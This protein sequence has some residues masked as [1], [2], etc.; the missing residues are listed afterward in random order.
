MIKIID[1]LLPHQQWQELHDYFL[2]H[3]CPW[4]YR[5]CM[6]CKDEKNTHFQF[7]QAMFLGSGVG[8]IRFDEKRVSVIQP[9]LARLNIDFLLRAKV[10]MTTRTHE[11]FQSDFHCDT[12]QNNLTAIY[13][14]NTCN[15]KTRFE[16]PDIEDVDSIAN[17]VIIFNAQQKHCT[18]T[19]TDVKARVVANINY[20]PIRKRSNGL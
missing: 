7:V 5:D 4:V 16:N 3:D 17:R 6:V 10:N 2:I 12:T 19:A 18:V 8:P 11:P 1:N 9:I 13:Y 20:L 14:V 15:G